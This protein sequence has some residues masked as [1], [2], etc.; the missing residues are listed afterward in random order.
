MKRNG[1]IAVLL[2]AAMAVGL[3]P[4][5][6]FAAT[7]EAWQEEIVFEAPSMAET[8]GAYRSGYIALNREVPE[9]SSA[10]GR[11]RAGAVPSAYM[12]DISALSA[13]Y[14]ATKEQKYN[15][16]WAFSAVGLAEFDMITDNQ[17]VDKTVD[18]SELQLSYFTYNHMEDPLEG[19]YG[20]TIKIL[21][22][23]LSFGGNLDS[24]ARTLLQ[25]QGLA[26][27]AS[28]PYSEASASKK[29]TASDAYDKNVVHLQ[30]VYCLN[31][32][33]NPTEVKQE[34]M[35]HGAAGIGYYAGDNATEEKQYISAG[36]YLG[37]TV[38]TFYCSKTGMSPNH[39]V[40]VVGWDDD[41]PAGNFSTTPPGNG[42]WLVRNSWVS[43]SDYSANT[44]S[45][46]WLSYYDATLEEAAWIYDFAEADDYDYNYQ[47]DGGILCYDGYRDS[48]FDAFANVFQVKGESNEQLEAVSLSLMYEAN[49][50]YTIKVY[51]NLRS[52]SKPR[53]GYLAAKVSGKT[54]YAGVYTVPLEKP[55]S[56]AKGTK[57]SVVIELGKK[58]S[59]IDVEC[60]DNYLDYSAKVYIEP[61]QSYALYKGAWRDMENLSDQYRTG[62]WCIKAYTGSLPGTALPKTQSLKKKSAAKKSI[63][64]KWGKVS[65]ADGYEIFRATSKN[66]VYKKVAT[67][68]SGSKTSYKNSGLSKNKT[69]YYRVRAYRKNT[70]TDGDSSYTTTTVGKMSDV[71]A[72]KT[73][74]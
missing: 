31:I 20:D 38:P 45:Y 52:G 55:V 54:S 44:S 73:S 2:T 29:L 21:G 40:N 13:R 19:T 37:R 56:L 39:A 49:M 10:D 59:S 12:N 50:P 41:F 48:G 72:V 3:T 17:T 51:T 28:I 62:N 26:D 9:L 60:A 25:W 71:A 6:A 5:T 27:E 53:S 47:Y 16:C 42:A 36:S 14:P 11:L 18:Y 34:I 15:D 46:F 57:Y 30:N 66:G 8:A 32:R 35:K 23:Y 7:G 58:K 24:A 1:K 64:L 61:E 74:K 70:V 69:Y 33:K 63:T 4:R 68:K 65:G 22:N 67:V 43:S